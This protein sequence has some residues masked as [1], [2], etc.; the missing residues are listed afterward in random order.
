MVSLIWVASLASVCMTPDFRVWR[1]LAETQNSER[2]LGRRQSAGVRAM[3]RS[4]GL[5]RQDQ[6][7]PPDDLRVRSL[8]APSVVVERRANCFAP[9]SATANATAAA[10]ATTKAARAG[11]RRVGAGSGSRATVASPGEGRSTPPRG[12]AR[13]GLLHRVAT[14]ERFELPTYGI[15]I[16]C[17]IQLSYGAVVAGPPGRAAEL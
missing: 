12:S 10:I 15:E 3:C 9:A 4:Y 8:R 16:H 6:Y 17:S 5:R 11:R 13:D 2:A 14:P 1:S 7:A